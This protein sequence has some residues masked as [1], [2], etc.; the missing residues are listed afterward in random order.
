MGAPNG[1]GQA[2]VEKA[3]E[4][5]RRPQFPEDVAVFIYRPFQSMVKV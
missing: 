1:E 3:K 4:D 5:A 2:D